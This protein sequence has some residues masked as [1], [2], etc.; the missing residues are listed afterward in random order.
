MLMKMPFKQINHS[1]LD[2]ILAGNYDEKMSNSLYFVTLIAETT[3][4][5]Y[6][7]EKDTNSSGQQ[8]GFTLL[9]YESY[10]INRPLLVIKI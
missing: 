10:Y 8:I 5:Y 4:G 6:Y 2:N 1:I 3:R 9:M 7:L